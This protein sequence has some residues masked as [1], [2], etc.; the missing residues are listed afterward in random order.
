MLW[1]FRLGDAEHAG[2]DTAVA[3]EADA[4]AGA[5]ERVVVVVSATAVVPA[6]AAATASDDAGQVLV[7]QAAQRLL[8]QRELLGVIHHRPPR[9]M[10]DMTIPDSRPSQDGHKWASSLFSHDT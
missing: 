5:A 4:D 7:V 9:L 8:R 10:R 6:A 1:Q 3:L 2:A